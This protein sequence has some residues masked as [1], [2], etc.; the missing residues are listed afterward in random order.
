MT[1]VTDLGM[2]WSSSRNGKEDDEDEEGE[3]GES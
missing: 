2:Y 3:A 1:A